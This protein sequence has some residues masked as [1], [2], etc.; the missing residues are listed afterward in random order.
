MLFVNLWFKTHT[1]T[2]SDK[3]EAHSY[4]Q[5]KGTLVCGLTICN[6]GR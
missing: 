4:N 6:V 2:I 1:V 3:F 5:A